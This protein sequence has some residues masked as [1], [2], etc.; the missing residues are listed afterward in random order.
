[1]TA[2]KMPEMPEAV[3]FETPYGALLDGE[4]YREELAVYAEADVIADRRACYLA[5]LE[6]AKACVPA[7]A[8]SA[9]NQIDRFGQ[10]QFNRCRDET[11]TNLSALE[12]EAKK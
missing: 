4:Y 3:L 6:A 1:M 11:L 10:G 5:G 8:T 9:T 7:E 2:N 12:Q